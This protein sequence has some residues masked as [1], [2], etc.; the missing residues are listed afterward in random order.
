MP[1]T[2]TLERSR[3]PKGSQRGSLTPERSPGK[4]I[5]SK[6]TGKRETIDTSVG[7]RQ[8]DHTRSSSSDGDEEVAAATV[9][10]YNSIPPEE[11]PLCDYDAQIETLLQPANESGDTVMEDVT[12]TVHAQAIGGIL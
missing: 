10:N 7:P 2:R 5:G 8:R 12:P 3:S 11:E 6:G 1:R 4:S 9:H